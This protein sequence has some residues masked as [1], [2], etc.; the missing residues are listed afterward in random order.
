MTPVR[1][2]AIVLSLAV[3]GCA[4]V[5]LQTRPEGDYNRVL[6]GTAQMGDGQPLPAG[7]VLSVRVVDTAQ[8]E[9][10]QPTAA[11]G[12]P[13]TAT[14]TVALPP[15]VLGERR[16]DNVRGPSIPFRVPYAAT[17]DQLR[18]GLSIEARVSVHGKVRYFSLSRSLD[19][20]NATD[21]PTI[22]LNH[23]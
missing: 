13:S 9:Y 16:F 4:G 5:Q 12:E 23:I 3:A 6:I 8:T 20:D 10:R 17:D 11:L 22:T 1:I 21:S 2:V 19:L 7:S 18:V 15:K 14:P